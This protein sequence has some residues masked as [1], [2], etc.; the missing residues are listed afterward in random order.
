MT[1]M[2]DI[3]DAFVPPDSD[4]KPLFKLTLSNRG[5]GQGPEITLNVP[6]HF[7]SGGGTYNGNGVLTARLDD[8]FDEYIA[9]V[10]TNGGD[11]RLEDL[12]AGLRYF[13][14]R[15]DRVCRN[16]SVFDDD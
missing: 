15:I 8:V 13:A 4:G 11:D 6:L 12:A 5:T 14:D 2:K 3:G 9:E 1:V 7:E 16:F 10:R